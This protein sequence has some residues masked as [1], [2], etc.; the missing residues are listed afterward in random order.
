MKRQ[1]K[2]CLAYGCEAGDMDPLIS[3]AARHLCDATCFIARTEASLDALRGIGLHGR[4]GTDTAWTTKPAPIE[5]ACLELKNKIGWDPA[6]PL[7]GV[8]VINPFWWPVKAEPARYLFGRWR[9]NPEYHYSGW[10]FLSDSFERRERFERYLSG[11]AGAVSDWAE[12]HH[13]QVVLFGMESIDQDACLKLQARLKAPTHVFSSLDYD[14]YQLTAL[15]RRLTVLVTSRYH[16]R[17]LSMPAGVPAIAISM[18]E[19]LH[20]LFAE[21]GHLE[22]YCLKADDPQLGSKL[23]A[24]LES[25]WANRE[26]VKAELLDTIPH[27]LRALADMG[28]TLRRYISQEFPRFPLPPEPADWLGYLPS[29]DPE[30]RALIDRTKERRRGHYASGIAHT[31]QQ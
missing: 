1:E 10:Y 25:L 23:S 2:P 13:A 31:L 3:Q 4:L 21:T 20:N 24:A 14:G 16:A 7:V 11:I 9:T 12:R 17:V 29:L 28:S 18:D 15:L 19:R 6:V 8:S 27:Y 26:G 5:W 22:R 30:L